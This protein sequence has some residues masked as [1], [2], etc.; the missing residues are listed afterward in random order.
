[1]RQEI[2]TILRLELNRLAKAYYQSSTSLVD[3]ATYDGMNR[4]L[5]QMEQEDGDA[6]PSPTNTI[7]TDHVDGF[8]KVQRT[9]PMLS[10]CNLYNEQDIKDW[11]EN[12][13]NAPMD[14]AIYS[15]EP[16]YDGISLS[17]IYEKGMLVQAST[18]GDG[19]EGD[20]VTSQALCMPSI[21]NTIYTKHATVE[22]RGEVIMPFAAFEK[23]NKNHPDQA[24]ANPRNAA[25]G[26]M[27]SYDASIVRDRGLQFYAYDLHFDGIHAYLTRQCNRLETL[28]DMGFKVTSPYIVSA[29]GLYGAV[30]G[31]EQDRAD[32]PFP[33]DGAV[34]KHDSVV[35]WAMLRH[36]G[37][38][39]RWA[40]A[41]KFE[42]QNFVSELLDVEWSVA[43]SG[44]IT[45]VAIYK[46]INMYGTTCQRATLNNP[47]W[48]YKNLKGLCYGDKLQL[49]KGGEIIPKVTGLVKNPQNTGILVC[50]P[51]ICP[52]CGHITK[53]QGANLYCTNPAAHKKT[54]SAPAKVEE[55]KPVVMTDKLRG[56]TILV[57]GNFG[58][59]Q[60]RRDIENTVIANGAK[61]AHGVSASVDYFVLPD[62]LEEWKHKAGSKWQKL[63]ALGLESR[64]INRSQ[65]YELA[66]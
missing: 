12:V 32:Y 9:R 1:M 44:R 50:H 17:L 62:N 59:P 4:L 40:A 26:T 57:S 60:A 20:D 54:A 53:M 11:M 46:P 33:I 58:T 38:Y 42:A 28:G 10:L 45:P 21:P 25:S 55:T 49:T 30:R 39:P 48:I 47:E 66:A 36:S 8:K 63:Q 3:D 41:Y 34:I 31:I 24:F 5:Q 14:G 27:K 2:K 52:E 18:R 23:W 64:I 29:K 37:K 65:F 35:A 43:E 7:M 6:V 56:K 61:L 13:A 51:G 16:K 19:Y 15:V 22:V